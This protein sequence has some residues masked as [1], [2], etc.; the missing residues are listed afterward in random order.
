M[1]LANFWQYLISGVAN[2]ANKES[3]LLSVLTDDGGRDTTA[4]DAPWEVQSAEEEHW[5]MECGTGTWNVALELLTQGGGGNLH[6][7]CFP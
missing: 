6:P 5:N 3:A 2:E 1:L 7:W 4:I